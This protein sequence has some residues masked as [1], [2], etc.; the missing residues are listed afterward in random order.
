MELSF[1][2]TQ[3]WLAIGGLVLLVLLSFGVG[4]VGGAMWQR[5]RAVPPPQPV[6][7]PIMSPVRPPASAAPASEPTR[8]SAPG[9]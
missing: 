2:R 4:F 6:T 9:G 3:W 1:T 7:P 5:A 8:P